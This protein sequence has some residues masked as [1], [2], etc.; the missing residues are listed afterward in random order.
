MGEALGARRRTRHPARAGARARCRGSSRR[1]AAE[2]SA[3]R[4]FTRAPGFSP[5]LAGS[6]ERGLNLAEAMEARGFG[7]PAARAR[8]SRPGPRLTGSRWRQRSWSHWRR[9]GSSRP[10]RRPLHL[11]RRAAAGARRRVA[12]HRAGRVRRAARLVGLRQVDA[13]PCAL[14]PRAA[15]PRWP[16]PAGSRWPGST[17]GR[18]GPPSSPAPSPRSFR[19]PRTRSCSPACLLAEVAFGLENVGVEP[20]EIVPRADAALAVVGAE[21][22]A[23][24]LV[25]ELSGGE[26]SSASASHRRWRLSRGCSSSMSPRL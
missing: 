11:S 5:L 17:R 8:R 19:S 25:A 22:L 9:C 15:L 10:R 18:P 16:V 24:R 13:S 14:G 12:E 20:A 4:V 2:G 21:H 23:G 1:C 7:R 26:S 6:L 3:S